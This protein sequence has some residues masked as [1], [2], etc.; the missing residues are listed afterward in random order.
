MFY[1]A[2]K[3]VIFGT[4]SH[5]VFPENRSSS[6]K[7]SPP[8]NKDVTNPKVE[9]PLTNVCPSNL[10][11]VCGDLSTFS[12]NRGFSLF[13]GKMFLLLLPCLPSAEHT[14]APHSPLCFCISICG[15]PF[16][17]FIPRSVFIKAN[18]RARQIVA[19]PS[20]AFTCAPAL[21]CS[22]SDI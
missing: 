3:D 10:F 14:P 13:F 11:L 1:Q 5:I 20:Y 16:Y 15:R 7:K 8:K 9:N 6:V 19:R 17:P 12:D 21:L 2:S 22:P 4:S 18:Y